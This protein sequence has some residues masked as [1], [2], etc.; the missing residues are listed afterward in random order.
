MH[1][2]AFHPTLPST[3]AAPR[4]ELHA[5]IHIAP[6]IGVDLGALRA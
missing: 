2:P 1:T 5:S 3:E 6:A 4:H